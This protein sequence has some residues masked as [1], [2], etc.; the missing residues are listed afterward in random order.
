MTPQASSTADAQACPKCGHVCRIQAME[1]PAC[2]VIM[3]KVARAESRRAERE[4]KAALGPGTSIERLAEARE[5]RIRQQVERLEAFTGIETCN[6]YRVMDGGGAPMFFAEEQAGEL[7]EILSRFILKSARPF[8][9]VIE[10]PEGQPVL[11]LERPFRFYFHELR[12]W[13]GQGTLLGTVRRQFS[14]L[15]RRYSVTENT[16]GARYDLH[17]PFFR[18]WTFKILRG[19]QGCGV[20]KKKWGGLTREFFTD[21]DGFGIEFPGNASVQAKSVLL[22]AVF[23]LDFVHFED[24]HNN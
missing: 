14:L 11:K 1:C 19:G 23:L 21:A 16:G 6:R 7:A 9:I 8:T 3:G 17:G 20:I 18:P 24:N 2:G 15:D 12:I 5:L 13:N 22:G 4:K 10:S